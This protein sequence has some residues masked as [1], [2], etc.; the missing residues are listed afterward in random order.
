[1]AALKSYIYPDGGDADAAEQAE[2]IRRAEVVTKWPLMAFLLTALFCLGSSAT[3]H[4]CYVRSEKVSFILTSVDYWG[5]CI[6][7]LGS[8]YPY[9][10][11]K[12]ACGPFIAWRYIFTSIITVLT[13]LCMWA[14]VQKTFMTPVRRVS[15][16]TLF[17][18]SCLC[19]FVMLYIWHDPAYSLA[20]EP[21]LYIWPVIC[22]AIGI[23]FYISRIPECFSKTGAYDFVG[24]SHQIFHCVV[25]LAIYM[26][27]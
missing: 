22:Y 8:C 19:P 9:I 15:L 16:F 18:I 7:F 13:A 21:G 6:L 24:A 2:T 20:P 17:F 11:F 10:S 14:T 4:L 27:F 25:L 1:M 23:F 5:I 12:Y 3:C 26:T